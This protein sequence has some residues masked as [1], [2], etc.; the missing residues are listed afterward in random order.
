MYIYSV[1]IYIYIMY[2]LQL[3]L[4]GT[5]GLNQHPTSAAAP[6]H[7]L[8]DMKQAVPA[9]VWTSSTQV[10]VIKT[11]GIT[12]FAGNIYIYMCIW[13]VYIYMCV[14]VIC[15]ACYIWQIYANFVNSI[16]KMLDLWVLKAIL[17]EGFRSLYLPGV[18][19]DRIKVTVA[20]CQI[21]GSTRF[22]T[23]SRILRILP[24]QPKI[25]RHLDFFHFCSNPGTR[26]LS[27]RGGQK[28]SIRLF[29]WLLKGL[30]NLTFLAEK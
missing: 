28:S 24:I 9:S 21:D 4:Q 25:W 17:G 20:C 18:T 7:Q 3:S 27:F 23:V 12:Q 1:D 6:C 14:C 15:V 26:L 19:C 10:V 29:S 22:S 5:C 16:Q 13:H 8:E 2:K 30:L 11:S